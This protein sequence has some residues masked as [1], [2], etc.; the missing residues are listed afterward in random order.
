[1][2]P[3]DTDLS[4]GVPYS[5]ICPLCGAKFTGQR[6][7]VVDI[8]IRPELGVRAVDGSLQRAFCPACIGP[9]IERAGTY[10]IARR[11]GDAVQVANFTPWGTADIPDQVQAAHTKLREQCALAG[12]PEAAITPVGSTLYR[13]PAEVSDM[14]FDCWPDLTLSVD[15]T[16]IPDAI[17]ELF[18]ATDTANRIRVLFAHADLARPN[19]DRFLTNLC[20][21]TEGSQRAAATNIRLLLDAA[22]TV[23]V[24]ELAQLADVAS[25]PAKYAE[26][27][28]AIAPTAQM[29]QRWRAQINEGRLQDICAAIEHQFTGN[30]E[31]APAGIISELG[32]YYWEQQNAKVAI[33]LLSRALNLAERQDNIELRATIAGNLG[34]IHDAMAEYQ[35]ALPLFERAAELYAQCGDSTWQL[36]M[37]IS[38]GNALSGLNEM[39]KARAEYQKAAALAKSLGALPQQAM[40]LLNLGA[41]FGRH[42][43]FQAARKAHTEALELAWQAEEGELLLQVARNLSYDLRSLHEAGVEDAEALAT[44]A[45]LAWRDRRYSVARAGVDA[46]ILLV[47][48]TLAPL[49]LADLLDTASQ[50]EVGSSDLSAAIDTNQKA[51]A[52]ARQHHDDRR[53]SA[54]LLN[55][56]AI[57]LAGGQLAAAFDAANESYTL[58]MKSANSM[59]AIKSLGNLG[60]ITQ[61]QGR[62]SQAELYLRRQYELAQEIQDEPQLAMAANAFGTLLFELGSNVRAAEL[63]DTASRLAEKHNLP[64]IAVSCLIN[65]AILEERNTNGHRAA[66]EAMYR[67]AIA[68]S[69]EHDSAD[70]HVDAAINLV[71][72]LIAKGDVEGTTTLLNTTENLADYLGDPERRASLV[73]LR[74]ELAVKQGRLTEAHDTF[75]AAGHAFRESSP[76]KSA[77][78]FVEAAAIAYQQLLAQE[79]SLEKKLMPEDRNLLLEKILRDLAMPISTYEGIAQKLEDYRLWLMMRRQEKGFRLYADVVLKLLGPGPALAVVERGR[80]RALRFAMHRRQSGQRTPAFNYIQTIRDAAFEAVTRLPGEDLAALSPDTFQ[81]LSRSMSRKEP[82]IPYLDERQLADVAHSTQAP[83]IEFAFGFEENLYVW[84][85]A[86][87]I[88]HFVELDLD[89][90]GGMAGLCETIAQLRASIGLTR[91]L[92]V[93]LAD[94]QADCPV[95]LEKLYQFLIRPIE[96]WLPERAGTPVCIIPDGP[97][98]DVPFAALQTA[99]GRAVLDRW[100]VFE[101][102]AIHFLAVTPAEPGK[103]FVVA[104]D[105]TTSLAAE[106]EW[107]LI[108]RLPFAR[109]EAVGVARLYG[110]TALVDVD[111]TKEKVYAAMQAAELVHLAA[112]AILS[113]TRPFESAIVLAATAQDDGFLRIRDIDLKTLQSRLVVLSCCSTGGGI[114]TGDGVLSLCRGLL[115]A[116]AHS[117][118]ASLWAVND[119]STCFTM[120]DFHRRLTENPFHDTLAE[121]FRQSQLATREK[122][123]HH[124]QWAPFVLW[125]WPHWIQS[126]EWREP[127]ARILG[128]RKSDAHSG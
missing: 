76:V 72:L 18:S 26:E 19:I 37:L 115:A 60:I 30:R 102:P 74:A 78:C 113:P 56:S 120:I 57:H 6:W 10:C 2:D 62:F 20:E 80:G 8:D 9:G 45:G 116:G 40:A 77:D 71:R 54:F 27:R 104:G 128:K 82:E 11:V 79:R 29:L 111:A 5:A 99:D 55:Q 88:V 47:D 42:G 16:L 31:H 123:P 122:Y 87:D 109:D 22:R 36:I 3:H 35:Q 41:D 93:E 107:G 12:I 46:A 39:K 69:I 52:L 89:A 4:V 38:V 53:A 101:I 63:L 50:F 70:T 68:L 67:K 64:H 17:I 98:F 48:E 103:G 73:S 84:V 95:L 61:Q 85:I 44:Q 86:G 81:A 1:M 106:K 83:V 127:D 33:E 43:E 51:V 65:L 108:S 125:G 97:L 58:A 23:G 59:V 15:P 92:G 100:S 32:N 114:V 96:S 7:V 14:V 34:N 49:Q 90:I 117:V 110:V 126:A 25:V 13:S 28:T 112:H 124:S 24:H 121:I 91:Q 75:Q 119:E 105:P 118:L 66:A 94:S 21:Q